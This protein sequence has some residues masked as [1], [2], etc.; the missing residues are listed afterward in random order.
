MIAQGIL[1][2]AAGMGTVF[3]FLVLMVLVMQA[4]GVYF[5]A[6]EERFRE[7]VPA[8]APR[9]TETGDGND[10]IAAVLAAVTDHLRKRG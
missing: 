7:L 2:M 8:A 3:V 6:N 4:A 9:K 5:K 10:V 1:L